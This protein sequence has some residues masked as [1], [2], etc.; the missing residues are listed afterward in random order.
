M[1]STQ[2]QGSNTRTSAGR[3]RAGGGEA[4]P[5]TAPPAGGHRNS[6]RPVGRSQLVRVVPGSV[7]LVVIARVVNLQIRIVRVHHVLLAEL[8]GLLIGVALLC[9]GCRLLR[10]FRRLL[11]LLVLL[12]K[13]S[14]W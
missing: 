12:Q 4:N 6:S 13:E 7:R 14:D 1:C 9:L 8:D 2:K 3:S 5:A 10:R 11:R